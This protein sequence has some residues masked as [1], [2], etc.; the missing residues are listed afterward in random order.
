LV[1]Q[2]HLHA[3][4]ILY[5]VHKF[6]I[7]ASARGRQRL[8]RPRNFERAIG[9]HACGC[10]RRFPGG[11]SPFDYQYL[12][13]PFAQR[14]RKREPDDAPANDNDVPGFHPSIV[15]DGGDGAEKT[16]FGAGRVDSPG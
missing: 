1:S 14:N 3:G 10:M 5:F 15:E 12:D 7:H 2:V 11:F 8:Q 16:R 13:A 6:R 4:L 9:Q